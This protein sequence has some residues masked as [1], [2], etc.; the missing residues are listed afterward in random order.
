[1]EKLMCLEDI[2]IELAHRLDE[3]RFSSP[4]AYVYNP[5]LYAW[6]PHREYLVRFGRGIKEAVFLGMNPGPWGM[7]QTGVPFGEIAAVRDWLKVEGEIGKPSSEHPKKRVVGLSCRRSEVSGRRL[8]GLIRQRFGSPE[9]FFERFFVLNYCPLLFLDEGG[10][11]I[12]PDKL[13]PGERDLLLEACDQA[14]FQMIECLRPAQVIGVGNFA[15]E[16][17]RNALHALPVKVGKILHPSPSNPL[18]NRCWPET[19]LR[20]LHEQEVDF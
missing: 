17:A 5:L 20:Q 10:R 11:N 19:V 16:Q 12:T 4:V 9:P 2:S 14:L 6:Q 8:W 1:M 13:R 15:A 3:L 7:T 18:A